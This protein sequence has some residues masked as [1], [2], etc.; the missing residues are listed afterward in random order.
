MEAVDTDGRGVGWGESLR[1]KIHVDLTKPL[2][3]GQML[4]L[5][6]KTKWITFQY[7]RLS[8]FGFN[9]RR[10]MH[11]CVGC[12]NRTMMRQQDKPPE[13][14]LWLRAP[15]PTRRNKRGTGKYATHTGHA[16]HH[17]HTKEGVQS[18]FTDRDNYGG[19]SD[20]ETTNPR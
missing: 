3:H 10:I 15:S 2:A 6:G 7:E 14:G 8:K 18:K 11:G 12:P 20:E 19:V 9:Y 13:Y 5:Q 1:V 4:K 16:N 17:Q